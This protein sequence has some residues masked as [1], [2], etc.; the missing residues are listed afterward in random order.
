[1]IFFHGRYIIVMG[2]VIMQSPYIMGARIREA[3]EAAGLTQKEL[4]EKLSYKSA[5][6]IAKIEK[7][8]NNLTQK[9][10]IAV[11]SVLGVTVGYLM[12]DKQEPILC[13]NVVDI[14]RKLQD[15]I[16]KVFETAINKSMQN[17]WNRTK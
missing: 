8:K 16:N 17:K 3:R 13:N 12:G 2:G 6:T 5:S 4:A 15:D 1:M 14:L 9:K 11:A 10:I 7:G